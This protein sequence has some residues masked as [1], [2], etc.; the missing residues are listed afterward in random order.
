MC[1]SWSQCKPKHKPELVMGLVQ[2]GALGLFTVRG[3]TRRHPSLFSVRERGEWM[4]WQRKFPSLT[5]PVLCPAV[6]VR[7]PM[8]GFA[9]LTWSHQ[10][11]PLGGTRVS[12][13]HSSSV[14]TTARAIVSLDFC[15][16]LLVCPGWPLT[17]KEASENSRGL[18]VAHQ[19]PLWLQRAQKMFSVVAGLGGKGLQ[20]QSNA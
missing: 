7:S 2:Q 18:Q 5:S 15:L 9:P 8:W 10:L 1:E 16:C 12:L 17:W 19:T 20:R 6:A 3:N 11:P 13:K 4:W 14:V